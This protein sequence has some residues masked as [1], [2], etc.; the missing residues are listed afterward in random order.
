MGA[1]SLRA[2]GGLAQGGKEGSSG[3]RG[4]N[5]EWSGGVAIP[6]IKQLPRD[7]FCGEGLSGNQIFLGYQR[8]WSNPKNRFVDSPNQKDPMCIHKGCRKIHHREVFPPLI[9]VERYQ[10]GVPRLRADGRVPRGR[11]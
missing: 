7:D 1:G 11:V 8:D 6:G 5:G 4:R 3:C 2:Q 10:K 9:T